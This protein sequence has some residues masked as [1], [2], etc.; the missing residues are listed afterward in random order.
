M[1][2]RSNENYGIPDRRFVTN[3]SKAKTLTPSQLTKVSDEHVCMSLELQQTF[4]LRREE[5]IKF[6]P[7]YADRVDHLILKASWTKAGKERSIPMRTE[8]Q[9]NVLNQARRLTDFGS[10]IPSNRNYLQ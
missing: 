10:L 1:V 3:A 4:G 6:Q 5:T 8:V 7:S 2:A 9:R